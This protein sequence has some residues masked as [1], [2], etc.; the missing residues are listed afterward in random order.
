MLPANGTRE[1]QQCLALCRI[2]RVITTSS[3]Y[4]AARWGQGCELSCFVSRDLF[5]SNE[6]TRISDSPLA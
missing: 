3:M 5:H 2:Q 4:I 6:H 1:N